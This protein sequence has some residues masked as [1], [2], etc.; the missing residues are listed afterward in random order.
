MKRGERRP[1][2]AWRRRAAQRPQPPPDTTTDEMAWPPAR[3]AWEAASAPGEQWRFREC[4]W[5]WEA[6]QHR[7]A[8]LE[9]LVICVNRR[10]PLPAWL[11]LAVVDAIKF[12]VQQP[13]NGRGRPWREIRRSELTRYKHAQMVDTGRRIGL[14]HADAQEFAAEWFHLT[15][16]TIRD[17][18]RR[19]AR[20]YN[21]PTY[22][23]SRDDEA[24]INGYAHDQPAPRLKASDTKRWTALLKKY[25]GRRPAAD[26]QDDSRIRF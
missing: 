17:S 22:F 19:V 9:A 16:H 1:G 4:R 7:T 26:F 21:T 2:R 5:A 25:E 8:L 10:I 23:F 15:K 14:T 11:G 13:V 20:A 12:W 6:G 3:S 24:F 18:Y